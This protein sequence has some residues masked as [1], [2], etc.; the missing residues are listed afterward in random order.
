MKETFSD[1]PEAI[2]NT[3][4]IAQRCSFMPI[5]SDPKLPPFKT[6]STSDENNILREQ[7][8]LGLK[9]RILQHVHDDQMDYKE[10]EV[11]AEPYYKRLKYELDVIEDMC[12]S[13]YF[14]I[15]A[16]FINWSKSYGIA[17]GPGR[18]LPAFF[19]HVVLTQTNLSS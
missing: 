2:Q 7:A 6:N 16:D 12:Y 10:K 5:A 14:L 8:N 13:G 1:L 19:R 18:M 15:V 17:V 4:V 9:E 11:V 3:M